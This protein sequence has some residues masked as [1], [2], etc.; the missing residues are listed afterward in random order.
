M[1][2]VEK[3]EKLGILGDVRQRCGS[4]GRLDDSCDLNI[5]LMTNSELIKEYT[6][7]HLGD[8]G[9][10]TK[11]K[12]HFDSLENLKNKDHLQIF[13]KEDISQGDSNES[14]K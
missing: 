14:R 12:G 7:W 2:N 10:W 11:L 8:G 13:E 9:W 3:L 6:A 4:D 5:N 1:T